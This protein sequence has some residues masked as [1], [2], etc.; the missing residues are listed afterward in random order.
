MCDGCSG[1]PGF[2]NVTA[3]SYS[4][5]GCVFT[6]DH[7]PS[8]PL[9]LTMSAAFFRYS[10][11]APVMLGASGIGASMSNL[12][13][14]SLTAFAVVGPNAAMTVPF[15]LNLGKFL[16]RLSMPPGLKNTSMSW[17]NAFMSLRSLATVL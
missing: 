4:P 6:V 11:I 13:P 14:A 8:T 17:V 7:F 3:G 10:S 5:S 1:R 2:I 9:R 12:N 16:R 15:C